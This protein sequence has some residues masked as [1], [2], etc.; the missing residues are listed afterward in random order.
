M[1][2]KIWTTNVSTFWIP[3][4]Y[5]ITKFLQCMNTTSRN[6]SCFWERE[7]FF[8][9]FPLIENYH[10]HIST[11]T[12]LTTAVFCFCTSKSGLTLS[13]DHTFIWEFLCTLEN[14]IPARLSWL[15][16]SEC[17]E[18]RCE[19]DIVLR[20]RWNPWQGRC[21]HIPPAWQPSRGIMCLEIQYSMLYF[22]KAHA[23]R[24][25]L[26]LF[27]QK[28]WNHSNSWSIVLLPDS[29]CWVL[30]QSIKHVHLISK[31]VIPCI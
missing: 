2:M 30:L 10:T 15:Q 1:T 16:F 24:S 18:M 22:Q 21:N 17:H 27:T 9:L 23:F 20:M 26:I 19:D 6:K 3:Q 25:S 12:I 29:E 28:S 8:C 4:Q 7:H 5:L 14:C 11:K 13:C 31:N